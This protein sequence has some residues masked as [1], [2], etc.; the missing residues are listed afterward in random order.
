MKHFDAIVIGGGAAGLM[1]AITAAKNGKSIALIEHNKQLGKKILISGGGRCNFTNLHTTYENF[2]SQNNRFCRFALKEFTQDDFIKMVED[3]K[4]DYF[5]KKLGQLFCKKS[6]KDIVNLFIEE[7][8]VKKVTLKLSTTVKK[9][10]L[11]DHYIVT[12]QSEKLSCDKLVIATGGL[13]LPSIGA[14]D[15]GHQLAKKFGHKIIPTKPGLVPLVINKE[16]YPWILDLA[17][18]SLEVVVQ[19]GKKK[20]REDFLITHKGFSGP[21]ILQISN[22]LE[23]SKISINFLPDKKVS[24]LIAKDRQGE[25][26][27]KLSNYL[28]Q[29]LP[30]KFIKNFL[31]FHHLD[32]KNLASLSKK[33]IINLDKI[34]HQCEIEVSGSEGYRKAEVT[35]GGVDTKDIDPKNMESKIQ[36]NLFFIGE[37]L[38]VTGHLGGFNFQWAW[39]SGYVCGVSI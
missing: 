6:A 23:D 33:D 11:E 13:S 21:A 15:F 22:Y 12:T 34:I 29:L 17:G 39:S 28:A 36:D 10:E 20:F 19:S 2:L 27:K 25:G 32:D 3:K 7:C 16:I 35:L 9:V 8:H 37:V 26:K 14:S 24:E 5:E 18:V 1:C 31:D 4:I 30:K 38:D